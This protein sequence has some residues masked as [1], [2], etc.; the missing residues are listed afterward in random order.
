MSRRPRRNHSAAFKATVAFEALAD[1]KTIAEIAQ[2]QEAGREGAAESNRAI[3]RLKHGRYSANWRKRCFEKPIRVRPASLSASTRW[4]LPVDVTNRAA[5]EPR[6]KLARG[7]APPRPAATPHRAAI[8]DRR[9]N[10]A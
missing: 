5:G 6:R 1:G 4:C 9:G 2:K 3:D 7:P 8:D 10:L